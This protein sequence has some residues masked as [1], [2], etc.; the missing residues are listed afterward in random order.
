MRQIEIR[1]SI[2]RHLGASYYYLTNTWKVLP[3]HKIAKDGY[4]ANWLLLRVPLVIFSSK[5]G[6]ALEDGQNSSGTV[7]TAQEGSEPLGYTRKPARVH[8]ETARVHSEPLG[9]PHGYTRSARKPARA[10]QSHH[11]P[12]SVGE[13]AVGDRLELGGHRE[14]LGDGPPRHVDGL[15]AALR[16]RHGGARASPRYLSSITG[17]IHIRLC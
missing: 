8:S 9:N 6:K 17:T 12:D 16:Q 5:E 2:R 13:G 3:Q 4:L 10:H 11:V 7:E 15:H 1:S 14:P